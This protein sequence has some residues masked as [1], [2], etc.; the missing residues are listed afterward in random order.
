MDKC[1]IIEQ[2][3]KE[4]WLKKA[5][6]NIG[7]IYADDLYQELFLLLCQK[8]EED[9][10]QIYPYIKWWSI[11]TMQRISS[12]GNK[13]KQFVK[14][15]LIYDESLSE[16]LEEI[17]CDH[18]PN[19]Y[20]LLQKA[21]ERAFKKAYWFDAKIFEMYESGKKYTVISRETKIYRT[22]IKTSIEKIKELIKQEYEYLA[23][24]SIYIMHGVNTDEQHH[25]SDNSKDETKRMDSH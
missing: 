22:T 3:S 14:N 10:Q 7:G 9:I 23:G 6:Q 11:V 1:E 13:H 5:S 19:N 2:L 18:D 24:N 8:S 12:P 17:P 21:K 20:D 16:N 25:K 15:F 4:K